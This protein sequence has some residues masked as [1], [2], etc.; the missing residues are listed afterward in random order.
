MYTLSQ[1]Y[2]K[3]GMSARQAHEVLSGAFS[4]ALE[5]RGKDIR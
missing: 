4:R 2:K 3:G 1:F 5:F